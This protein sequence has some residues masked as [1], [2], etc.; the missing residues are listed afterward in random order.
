MTTRLAVAALTLVMSVTGST[1]RAQLPPAEASTHASDAIDRLASG[2]FAAVV[3]DFDAGMAAALPETALRAAWTSL[4][5][6]AGA[7]QRRAE[8]KTARQGVLTIATVTCHFERAVIDVQ[9]T[10][11]AAGRIAGLFFLPAYS[12]PPYATAA[13]YTERDVTIGTAPWTL[14]G[15][16]TRPVRDALVPAVVL[17]H[18]SGAG[19]RDEA[20]GPNKPFRDLALGLASRGIAVLRYDKRNRA[21]PAAFA[22]IRGLTVKDETID[23]ALAAVEFLRRDPSIDAR[24]IVV[25]GHSL[26][27]MVA[28]RIGQADSRI[29]GLIVMAGNTR[30]ID[31]MV[32]EQVQYLAKAD[33]VIT[34]QEQAQIDAAAQTVAS[35]AR[36]TPADVA[37]PAPIGGIPVSYWLDMR[38][39]DPPAVARTLRQPLLILQGERDYQVTTTDLNAWK[40]GLAGK[41]DV[42]FKSYPA[43]NHLMIPGSGKSLPAE[44]AVP[45]HVDESVVADIAQ[46]VLALPP[47]AP[48]AEK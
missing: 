19:D 7:F 3:A 34:P 2:Q 9:L 22:A 12:D 25:L 10:F 11:D 13:A 4:G 36:L 40:A 6:Q 46:W 17:V 24:R 32:A 14:P 23:D 20:V 48:P 5:T 45:G 33:G 26:G 37:N 21:Y 30:Q 47:A 18:G 31:A 29:A 8:V 15:T 39:Y 42:T 41:A 28:P 27:G 16:L 1:L 35:V 43:L 38:G 44:Y